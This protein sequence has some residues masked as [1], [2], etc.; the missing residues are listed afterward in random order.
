ML[1]TSE[2]KRI[3]I[4][5]LRCAISNFKKAQMEIEMGYT[6]GVTPKLKF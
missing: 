6:N 3:R 5:D 2:T 1:I 4:W